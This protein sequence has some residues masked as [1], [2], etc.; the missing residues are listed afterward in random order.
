MKPT[1][2]S[3]YWGLA[4]SSEIA[5]EINA[6]WNDH[7]R[8]LSSSGYGYMVQTMYDLYYGIK[9][10]G[11][12]IDLSQDGSD[13]KFSVNHYKSLLQ[14]LHS[15][16]TQSKL[17]YVPRARNSDAQSQMQ[18]DFAKGLLEY[19][20]DD[21]KMSQVT[22]EMVE[23]GL[24]MLDSFVFAPWDEHQG[25]AIATAQGMTELRNGD[26]AFY[27]LS[28]FDVATHPKLQDTPY[29][30]VKLPVNKYDLAALHPDKAD[31]IISL[32]ADQPTLTN[33]TLIN[34]FN[35]VQLDDDDTVYT[36]HF[37]HDRTPAL[38]KGRY[39]QIVGNI[40]LKD[41]ELGY[42][43]LPIIRFSGA[44]MQQTPA[45]D[46]P[47]TM[48]VGIQQA[49]DQIYSSNLSNNLH[50]NKQS[51]WSP[52]PVEIEKLSEG[53]NNIISPQKPE[54]LQLTSSSSESYKLLQGLEGVAQTL[55]GVNAT[56]RGNPESS[57]KSGTSLALMLSISVMSADSIQKNYAQAAADLGT[58]VIHNL[59][60]FA[61]EP[62]IAYIGGVSKGAQAREFKNT[63]INAIDR[64][65]VDIGNPLMSNFGGRYELVQQWMQFGVLKDPKKIV[66]F[67]R[68]GQ[69]DSITEDQFKD[70]ILIRE[71]NELIRKGEL[72]PVSIYD[73][74]PEHI[75]EHKQLANDP[76]IRNNPEIIETLN[77]HIQQ[78]LD[79]QKTMDPDLAAILGIPPL[80]SQQMAM[81]GPPPAPGP[82]QGPPE[83]MDQNLPNV[84]PN[85]PPIAE[86][87]FQEATQNLPDMSNPE[88]IIQ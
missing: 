68:T 70:T 44:K 33:S 25:E 52:T 35:Q 54:S 41:T 16:T 15:I 79:L 78:H 13:A 8:W 51:I 74:H 26:Q 64:I 43:T 87:A 36:Y 3:H 37:L 1:I 81:E 30:I 6:K 9:D 88:G 86:E 83:I 20:A 40:V 82:D 59:Q 23:L 58:I 42:K 85:A 73:L 17:Q 27:L 62:R 24:V 19:Y 34:P 50:F 67:L 10:G 76:E 48:L 47:G 55:S 4:P 60:Q 56:T 80:P 65:S 29:Y 77:E 53:F 21:K 66:E 22:S 2:R 39:T 45:G 11:F 46:S 18:T 75:L 32:S 28:R 12:E 49:I 31:E 61:T 5:N 84:P 57:L 72:P 63:D 38:P 71:E 14:R 7:E 69:V